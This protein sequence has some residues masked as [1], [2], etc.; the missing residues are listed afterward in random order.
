MKAYLDSLEEVFTQKNYNF[1]VLLSSVINI[2]N[3]V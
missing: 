3:F 1:I 2:C